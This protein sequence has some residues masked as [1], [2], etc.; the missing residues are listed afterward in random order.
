MK[1][2]FALMLTALLCAGLFAVFPASPALAE[3]NVLYVHNWQDYLN[4][5]YVFGKEV[6]GTF[7]ES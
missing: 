5:E 7:V 2:T 4:E 6:N 1:K 3:D